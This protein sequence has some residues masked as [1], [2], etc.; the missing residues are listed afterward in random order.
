M[1]VFMYFTEPV[2]TD[3]WM[4]TGDPLFMTGGG[5]PGERGLL[6][7]AFPLVPC[8]DPGG[9]SLGDSWPLAAEGEEQLHSMNII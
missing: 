1:Y 4:M 5:L 3:D 2:W 9:I 8:S 7:P 6:P